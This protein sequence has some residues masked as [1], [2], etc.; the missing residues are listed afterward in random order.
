[1]ISVQSAQPCI[2]LHVCATTTFRESRR[3]TRVPLKIAIYVENVTEWLECEGET[4]VVN[5]H[6]ALITTTVALS[7]GMTIS[8]H[9]HLTDKH[10]KARVVYVAPENPLRCGIELAHPRNIWCVPLPP[11]DWDETADVRSC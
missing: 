11:A 8:I 3:S 5:L 7:V 4:A 10:A 1:V 2:L 9:V 6:G